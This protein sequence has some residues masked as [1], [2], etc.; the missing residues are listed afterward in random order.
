MKLDLVSPRR[1]SCQGRFPP[2]LWCRPWTWTGD[3]RML[4]G[5]SSPTET[6][7]GGSVKTTRREFLKTTG[8]AGLGFWMGSRPAL[9]RSPNEK[10]NVGVI[11]VGGRGAEDLQGVSKE[12]VAALCDIDLV[13]LYEA[14][15]RHPS[16]KLYTDFRK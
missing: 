9:S 2:C 8:L 4:S 1:R 15:K 12:N 11:G 3:Y 14:S 6:V 13:T 7:P 10:L 5:N 16:A